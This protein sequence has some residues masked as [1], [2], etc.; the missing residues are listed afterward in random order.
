MKFSDQ[1]GFLVLT[2][3]YRI[4]ES[5]LP[6]RFPTQVGIMPVFFFKQ[7]I[8]AVAAVDLPEEPDCCPRALL[9]HIHP[10]PATHKDKWQVGVRNKVLFLHWIKY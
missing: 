9:R 3:K 1:M 2:Y 10:H 7:I 5:V 6:L 8:K 4:L